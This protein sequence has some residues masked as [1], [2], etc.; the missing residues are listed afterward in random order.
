MKK[1][2]IEKKIRELKKVII[3]ILK[4]NGVVKAGVFGSF[5]RGD[6]KK[7]SDIDILIKPPKG[8]GFGFVGIQLQLQKSLNKKVDLLS[9]K[10]IHPLLKEKILK[11]EVRIL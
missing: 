7:N 2:V 3:P 8:I 1:G 5:V 4:R 9:Y 11:E 10:A 6:D